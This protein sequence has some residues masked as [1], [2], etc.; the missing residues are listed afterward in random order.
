MPWVDESLCTGCGICV[1]SCPGNAIALDGGV[2][3]IDMDAC[4][5]CGECHEFCP[6]GAICHDGDLTEQRINESVRRVEE[7]MAAC[8]NIQGGIQAGQQCLERFFR[9][10]RNERRIIDEVVKKISRFRKPPAEEGS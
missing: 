6:R 3:V 9:H 5:R 1:D 7:C 8:E 4:I 10:Y 2:A